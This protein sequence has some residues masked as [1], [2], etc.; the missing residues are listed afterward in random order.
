MGWVWSGCRAARRGCLVGVGWAYEY[1]AWRD[2][3]RQAYSNVSDLTQVRDITKE[4][5]KVNK[6]IIKLVTEMED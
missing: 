1:G 5:I 4:L 6:E 2:E 3:R